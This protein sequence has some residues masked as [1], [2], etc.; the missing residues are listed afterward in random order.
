MFCICPQTIVTNRKVYILFLIL[1]YMT[2]KEQRSMPG[3]F[4]FSVPEGL[5]FAIGGP[6]PTIYKGVP[7]DGKVILTQSMPRENQFPRTIGEAETRDQ[8]RE[9]L[10]AAAKD[11]AM[12]SY[13][14]FVDY[15][16]ISPLDVN[17]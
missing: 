11:R 13:G 16:N 2:N 10:L 8:A 1:I 7:E 17:A 6:N 12:V 15:T 4:D 9:V 5:V 14:G 3:L